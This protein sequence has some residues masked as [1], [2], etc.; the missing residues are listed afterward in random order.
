[1]KVKNLTILFLKMSAA[2]ANGNCFQEIKNKTFEHTEGIVGA[3]FP[4]SENPETIG[5][6]KCLD[7]C[8]DMF[9]CIGMTYEVIFN[10]TYLIRRHDNS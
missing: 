8:L 4:N 1:M 2:Y 10:V 9:E 5:Y 7:N 3:K 6:D